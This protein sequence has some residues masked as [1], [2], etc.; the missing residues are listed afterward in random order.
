MLRLGQ[1]IL[2][3]PGQVN[4]LMPPSTAIG[5]AQVTVTSASG[6]LA[7]GPVDVTAVAS[8]IFAIGGTNVAAA[9][10][11]RVGSPAARNRRS[12]SSSAPF[13]TAPPCPSIW[14][15]AGESVFLTSVRDRPSQEQR[16]DQR[17]TP[18]S[19]AWTAPV[20]FAGSQGEFAGLDQVNVQIP[21]AARGRGDVPVLVTVDGQITN[22]V[23]I[24]VR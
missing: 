20:T 5:R 12:L 23:I 13:Q 11:L 3:A 4:F 7:T 24:N 15:A 19:A 2:A 21:A 1:M 16:P 18:P 8:S 17:S 9:V 22:P 14:E 6:S 10:A